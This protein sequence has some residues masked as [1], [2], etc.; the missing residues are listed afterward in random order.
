MVG[1]GLSDGVSHAPSERMAASVEV[2]NAV[3]TI[4]SEGPQRVS[5]VTV[6]GALVLT[7]AARFDEATK[8]GEVAVQCPAHSPLVSWPKG[9]TS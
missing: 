3:I 5:T 4:T 8:R 9:S 6:D 2:L 1:A 7:V